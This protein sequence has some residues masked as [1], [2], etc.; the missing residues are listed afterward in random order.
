MLN[1]NQSPIILG[2]LHRMVS[3]EPIHPTPWIL[4]W[5]VS[6]YS[7]AFFLAFQQCRCGEFEIADYPPPFDFLL[8]TFL[9]PFTIVKIGTSSITLCWLTS[10]TCHIENSSA[11]P[12]TPNIQ[13][14][15]RKRYFG[16]LLDCMP[17]R[18]VWSISVIQCLPRHSLS[19]ILPYDVVPFQQKM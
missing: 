19:R 14:V 7:L 10:A 1:I 11:A 13:C 5:E 17:H 2:L 12:T 8:W 3:W 9:K 4:V 16:S 15:N 6:C 18:Q